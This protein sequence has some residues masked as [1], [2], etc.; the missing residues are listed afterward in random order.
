MNLEH[1]SLLPLIVI[2]HGGA[3]AVRVPASKKFVINAA[4]DVSEFSFYSLIAI[5]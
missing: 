5:W 4:D 2:L 3:F 1:E